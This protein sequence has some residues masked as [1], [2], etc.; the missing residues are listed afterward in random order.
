M[1]NR[2]LNPRIK[3]N[4]VENYKKI[5][6]KICQND[7]KSLK[8]NNTITN[9][10]QKIANTFNVYFLTIADSVIGNIKG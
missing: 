8:I 6:N 9:N 5:G 2:Y 1:M 10:T 4:Y 3:K 7:I